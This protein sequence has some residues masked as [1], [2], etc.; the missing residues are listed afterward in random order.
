MYRIEASLLR[1]LDPLRSY[2][3]NN[4]ARRLYKAVKVAI[5]A[6]R[7]VSELQEARQGP[8]NILGLGFRAEYPRWGKGCIVPVVADLG[9]NFNL[10]M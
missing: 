6:C 8:R 2:I 3:S 10:S 1:G 9:S 5:G 4:V 7:L